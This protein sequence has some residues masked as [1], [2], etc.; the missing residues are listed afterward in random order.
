MPEIPEFPELQFE[1]KKHI[2]KL[3]G[4][5]VPSVT[6][7]M[8]PLSREYYGGIDE[9]TL[10]NAAMRGDSVHS[11]IESYTLYGIKDIETENEGYLEAAIRWMK[12]YNVEPHSSEARIYHKF[13]NYA[14]TLDLS[15]L[16]N[17]VS[18][19]VD[20]KTTASF[21]P[22]LTGVQLEAYRKALE[23]HGIHHDRKLIIQLKKDGTYIRRDLFPPEIEC[24][25]TFNALITVSNYMK[26]Y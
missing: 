21:S 11:A 14:G 23:S 13:L 19:L 3:N 6:T 15:C 25:K 12:D 22:M 1:P 8:N 20:F 18:T 16:E 24:W 7:L 26:Q 4:L 10:H 2:Y 9:K 5:I 17:G